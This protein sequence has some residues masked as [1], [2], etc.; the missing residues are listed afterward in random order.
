M[1]SE[2]HGL[3]RVFLATRYSWQGLRAA[4]RKEEAFRQEVV[5]ALIALPVAWFLG[6]TG[7]ERALLAAVVIN[8]LVIELVNTAVENVVD[9]I[10]PDPHKLSGRAKDVG[11]AAV[12]MAI[13]LAAVVWGLVLFA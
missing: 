10:G 1:P 8:V 5:V 13:V 2:R 3:K 12:F 6:D 11:S 9:R 7:V 4:W